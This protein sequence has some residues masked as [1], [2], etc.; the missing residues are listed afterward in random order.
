MCLPPTAER[1][2]LLHEAGQAAD[3]VLE[4]FL[5]LP[6][7]KALDLGSPEGFDR[8]S[9]L[10]AARLRRAVGKAD[11]EAVRAAV[12]VL[13]VDWAKTT[14]AQRRGLVSQ[15]M[16]AAGRATAVIPARIQVPL[17]DAAE[18]VVAAT[19]SHA[20]RSQGL[21]IGADFN[22]LDRR[23]AAHVVA[24][25]GNFVRDEYGRRLDSLSEKARDIVASGLEQG[26]G[27]ADIAGELERAARAALIERSTFY[28]ELVASSFIGRGRSFA[29]MS[30]YAEAGIQ[31]YRI[32]AVL[33]ERT[34]H[35]C[36]YLHGKTFEVADALQRFERVAGLE[37]PEDIKLEQPWVR[38]GRDAET[39][40]TRL[41]VE[42]GSGRMMIAEVTRSAFGTRDDAGDFRPLASDRGLAEAGV[43]FP[44]F[45]AL[46]RTTCLAA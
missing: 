12:S 34:T 18:S 17:G 35:I 10:L 2:L 3:Q 1:L 44:P 40:R 37:Q 23:V 32:E 6:V 28:W 15:A 43:G 7:T 16:E 8:A 21:A 30:S 42:G 9:A 22:A 41:Y 24:S 38:E 27:R 29:Q 20:R 46:C 11:A 39:G 33:D 25:Q 19:R 14:A 26:L 31:R 4:G 13:D 5:R 36:R 45:H